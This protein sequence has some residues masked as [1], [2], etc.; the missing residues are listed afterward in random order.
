M[1]LNWD[2]SRIKD[3]KTTCWVET[4]EKD[5]EGKPLK[6]LSPVTDSLIWL[7]LAVGMGDLNEKTAPEFFGRVRF[8]ED[9]NGAYLRKD[10]KP[11]PITWADVE[12]NIGLKTNVSYEPVLSWLKRLSHYDFRESWKNAMETAFGADH[13]K[14]HPCPVKPSYRR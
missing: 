1:S 8:Y 10:G 13:W 7:M 6:R 3:Y 2:L 4:G 12:A 14:T 11:R 9:R 5:E